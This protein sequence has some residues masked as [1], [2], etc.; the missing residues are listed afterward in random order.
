MTRKRASVEAPS[1]SGFVPGESPTPPPAKVKANA[2]AG[3]AAIARARPAGPSAVLAWL[4]LASGV[5]VAIAAAL[6]VA[7]GVLR[8]TISTP[9]FAVNRVELEG[10][11]RLT[12]A[13]VTQRMGLELGTNIFK[14]DPEGAE[15]KLLADP[16]IRQV[17]VTRRLP[18]TLRVELEER[19]ATAVA[20][21]GEK[22]YLVTR[23]GEPFKEL[24]PKDPFD[25]PVVTGIAA[26]N[27]AKD[28]PR[29]VSRIAIALEV[30]RHWQ[31][32]PSS[33]VYPAQEIHLT[34]GGDVVLT[35]GKTG[36]TFHLGRGPW[37]RKLLMGDRVIE[38]LARRG[39]V[40]GIIFLDNRA[41]PD[42]VVVR[43]R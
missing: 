24:E 6:A 5:V 10:A 32:I 15:Q 19:D 26:E 29:E 14:F 23:I 9:R 42:R 1:E 13:Q 12:Q 8:Y 41:H 16:W 34:E 28:R 27:L 4:K 38:R 25:L 22:L 21:I 40:P 37:R 18:S 20:A 30:L 35:A 31:K 11:E 3:R 2:R 39:R 43:M 33:Q 7:W 36:V 17:K